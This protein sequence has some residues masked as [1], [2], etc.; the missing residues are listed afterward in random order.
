MFSGVNITEKG[1]YFLYF[2][3]NTLQYLKVEGGQSLK[4]IEVGYKYLAKCTNLTYLSL[5]QCTMFTRGV[6]FLRF[7]FKLSYLDLGH[8][9]IV[10]DEDLILIKSKLTNLSILKIANTHD[11]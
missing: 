2:I 11:F 1:L 5:S 6:K 10:E 7:L 9:Y 8:S 4:I 3:S